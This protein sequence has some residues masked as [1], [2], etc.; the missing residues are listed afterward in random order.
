MDYGL[1]PFSKISAMSKKK[2]RIFICLVIYITIFP[3]KM[4]KL[5]YIATNKQHF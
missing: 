1:F 2:I 5:I 4:T 3:S